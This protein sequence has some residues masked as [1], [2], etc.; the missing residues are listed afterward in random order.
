M[1]LKISFTISSPKLSIFLYNVIVDHCWKYGMWREVN[2]ITHALSRL[3]VNGGHIYMFLLH[4]R[5]WYLVRI[6]CGKNWVQT[7]WFQLIKY[8]STDN[9][10]CPR[11]CQRLEHVGVHGISLCTQYIRNVIRIWSISCTRFP[12]S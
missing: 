3:D 7:D 11:N 5:I 10:N 2:Y 4:H 6:A 12:H 1:V 8:L 9:H